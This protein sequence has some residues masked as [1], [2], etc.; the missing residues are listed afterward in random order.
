MELIILKM[1]FKLLFLLPLALL[2]GCN[3]D[4]SYYIRNQ[5]LEFSYI[6][7]E[8]NVKQEYDSETSYIVNIYF[9]VADVSEAEFTNIADETISFIIDSLNEKD[10]VEEY[11]INISLVEDVEDQSI[12]LWS[13][14]NLSYPF[15]S[16][17]GTFDF[18]FGYNR[19][20]EIR[21]CDAGELINHTL[22]IQNIHHLLVENFA[23]DVV[24]HENNDDPV[25]TEQIIIFSYEINDEE[26]W[27]RVLIVDIEFLAVDITIETLN[28]RSV[29]YFVEDTLEIYDFVENILHEYDIEL[30]NLMVTQRD[31]IVTTSVGA[32]LLSWQ[33]SDYLFPDEGSRVR[34]FREDVEYAHE[35]SAGEIQGIINER[36]SHVIQAEDALL[37]RLNDIDEIRVRPIWTT[38]EWDSNNSYSSYSVIALTTTPS[39]DE[40]GHYVVNLTRRIEDIF[41]SESNRPLSFFGLHG[42][43]AAVSVTLADH[44]EWTPNRLRVFNTGLDFIPEPVQRTRHGVL[45]DRDGVVIIQISLRELPGYLQYF[46]DAGAWQ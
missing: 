20:Y 8:V 10:Y 11:R 29:R 33:F 23:G 31:F 37:E 38:S 6:D 14:S 21:L 2:M 40:F 18:H 28:H 5:I 44:V 34:A 15:G 12:L 25:M 16:L 27:G 17:G 24:F 1:L 19:S 32:D 46:I 13:T 4:S 3:N 26:E 43:R 36:F 9:N 45:R 22:N 30:R 41:T 42:E 35:L 7:I 39:I